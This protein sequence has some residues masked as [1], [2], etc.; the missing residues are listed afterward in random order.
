VD[1]T[2]IIKNILH[3]GLNLPKPPETRDSKQKRFTDALTQDIRENV[4]PNFKGYI[5]LVG[6]QITI[7]NSVNIYGNPAL[8]TELSCS[9]LRG[10]ESMKIRYRIY[11][12]SYMSLENAK[13]LSTKFTMSNE[14]LIR[15]AEYLA[16]H[17]HTYQDDYRDVKKG[18]KPNATL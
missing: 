10:P 12:P 15:V 3:E 2:N 7:Y 16:E 1:R 17:F 9:L 5:W 8:I 18:R 11:Q 6:P 14:I 4:D 13:E